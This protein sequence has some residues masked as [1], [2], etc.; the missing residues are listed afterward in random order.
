MFNY[1]SSRQE[2]GH[3]GPRCSTID[4]EDRRMATRDLGV[5]LR[6]NGHPGPRCSTIDLEDRRMA[7][8]DLGVQL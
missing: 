5:E 2:N 7:T 6:E 4:L 3:P 8:R 1:R